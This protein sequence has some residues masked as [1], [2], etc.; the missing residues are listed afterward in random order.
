MNVR[1]VCS[2]SSTPMLRLSEAETY[3]AAGRSTEDEE[4]QEKQRLLELLVFGHL[5]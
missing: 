3:V 1:P 5:V 2:Y 4:V